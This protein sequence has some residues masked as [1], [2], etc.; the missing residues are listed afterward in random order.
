MFKT[1]DEVPQ[2]ILDAYVE[3]KYNCSVPYATTH[4]W[5]DLDWINWI[6][7]HGFFPILD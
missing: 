1:M 3:G 4:R 2:K 5:S 6:S 7:E